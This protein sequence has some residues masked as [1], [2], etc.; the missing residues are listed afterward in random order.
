MGFRR[1]M[2]SPTLRLSIT[3]EGAM[4]PP[5]QQYRLLEVARHADQLGVDQID[6][7]E[8]VLMGAGALTSGHGW[9]PRHLEMPQPDSIT[10]MAAMAGAT[11]TIRLLSNV[12]IAP[13]RPAGLL[14][15]A[16]AT[17]H[18]ISRGRYSLGVS[19]SWHK[20]E[21]DALG[22]PFSER[23]QILDD[24]LHACRVLWT[25]APASFHSK[26]VNFDNMYC[27]P[28]PAPGE[29]I[30]ILFGGHFAP[31]LIRRIVTLGDGWL[32]S[33]VLGLDLAQKVDAIAELKEA[34]VNAGRDAA[35]LELCDEVRAVDG[36]IAKSMEEIPALARAGITTVRMHLR[37]FLTQPDE[38]LPKLEEIVRR[39][40]Q[41]REVKSTG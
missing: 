3:A 36:D 27:S 33:G 38:A 16:V 13:L 25:Q 30:P 18:A 14:A 21:Y 26:T 37:R 8:H 32:L 34:F 10:S 29:R 6:T 40:E 1:L 19:V 15:K 22:V 31:R 20:D 5:D 35:T 12:A 23:G 41:Y 17:V 7:S 9:E 2:T 39:F 24:Q 28:R 11:H 4:F